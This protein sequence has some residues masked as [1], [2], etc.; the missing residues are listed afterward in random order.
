[1]KISLAALLVSSACTL[2]APL[3]A[4][5]DD[6]KPLTHDEVEAVVKQV[7]HDNPELIIQAVEDYQQK[8]QMASVSK[9]AQNIISLQKD[10]NHDPLSPSIGNPKG[11]VTLVEF[12][13]Y[14]CGY[15]KHFFPEI[16]KLLKDD[17]N[18]RIVFK[19]F[20]ILSE[21]SETASRAALAVY[22]IDPSKY[23]EFHTLLMKSSGTFSQEML[24]GKAKEI[25][26]SPEELRK[27]MDDPNISK[28][29]ERNK[30]MAQAIDIQGTPGLII[31]TSMTPG[32]VPY[33]ILKEKI[34]D[35][36]SRGKKKS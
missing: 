3:G 15:C 19:E 33:D 28:E 12:F 36:R 23:F 8:Q 18:V 21:D 5:A 22:K 9:A 2:F 11:D 13:D 17:P 26:I 16:G 31:G 25:G 4:S 29:L 14:H 27:A 6:A 24:E 1:M 32:A 34:A 7:I 20:P 10:L 35:V 30:T